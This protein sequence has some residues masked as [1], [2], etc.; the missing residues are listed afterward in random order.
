MSSPSPKI[1][2]THTDRRVTLR[3]TSM[4]VRT[5]VPHGPPVPPPRWGE[6]HAM[7]KEARRGEAM[8]KHKQHRQLFDCCHLHQERVIFT[9]RQKT[10]RPARN[11]LCGSRPSWHHGHTF[12]KN[13]VRAETALTQ[14]ASR[15]KRN[16]FLNTRFEALPA[17]VHCGLTA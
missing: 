15:R 14:V 2:G 17:T 10:G 5:R 12:K 16:R 13:S 7:E 11:T 3:R 4:H 1:G 9:E 6:R 8:R